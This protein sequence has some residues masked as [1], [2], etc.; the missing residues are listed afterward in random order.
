MCP[1]LP[2]GRWTVGRSRERWQGLAIWR[3]LSRE[4]HGGL[5]AGDIT[6]WLRCGCTSVGQLDVCPQSEEEVEAEEP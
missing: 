2:H 4:A 5:R 6:N 1:G 3:L